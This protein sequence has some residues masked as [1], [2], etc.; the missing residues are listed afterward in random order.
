MRW[1]GN[2]IFRGWLTRFCAVAFA[3]LLFSSTVHPGEIDDL[4]RNLPRGFF[5]EFSWEG[6]PTVQ[7]VV[8]TLDSVRALNEQNAE[9]L[10]CGSYEVGRNVTRIKVR[11]F[12]RLSDL[13]VEIF[14][15]APEGNSSFETGGSHRGKLSKDFQR[16]DTEWTTTSSGQRGELHLRALPAVTCAPAEAT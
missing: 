8:I 15:L 11:M 14:E 3:S 9:A 7:N 6:D 10:G 12:V 1:Q 5:G 13:Q 2:G 4:T 16:I